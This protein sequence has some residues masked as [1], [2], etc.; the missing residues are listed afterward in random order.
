MLK[1]IQLNNARPYTVSSEK[2]AVLQNILSKYTYAD[3][4]FKYYLRRNAKP[5]GSYRELQSLSAT[6]RKRKHKMAICVDIPSITEIVTE[7]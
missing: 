1:E 2:K 6:S 3:N 5:A 4:P 7:E